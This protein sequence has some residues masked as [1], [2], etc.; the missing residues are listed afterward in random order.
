MEGRVA[1]GT[2]GGEGG[3]GK[4]ER[5]KLWMELLQY[6]LGQGEELWAPTTKAGSQPHACHQHHL[7]SLPS[8]TSHR[9]PSGLQ[10]ESRQIPKIPRAL[11]PPHRSWDHIQKWGMGIER[12]TSKGFQ[13]G[14]WGEFRVQVNKASIAG[15]AQYLTQSMNLRNH[16]LKDIK[17]ND[18]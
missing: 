16:N 10:A 18:C 4:T 8:L 11:K 15:S 13:T 2:D 1:E 14:K 9:R 7:S 12:T 5:S 17:W 3:G 6:R